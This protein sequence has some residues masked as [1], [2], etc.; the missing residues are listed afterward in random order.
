MDRVLHEGNKLHM[1]VGQRELSKGQAMIVQ[2]HLS[3]SLFLSRRVVLLRALVKER[4]TTQSDVERR[5][6]EAQSSPG[7]AA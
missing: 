6:G 2:R 1:A 3:S 4:R 5:R 7:S